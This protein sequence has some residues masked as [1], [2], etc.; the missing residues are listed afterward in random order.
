MIGDIISH[1]EGHIFK[2]IKKTPGGKVSETPFAFYPFA[3]Y[4]YN[5]VFNREKIKTF[6][7]RT[8]KSSDSRV[9]LYDIQ[10]V[11]L[12]KKI[13]TQRVGPPHIGKGFEIKS[14]VDIYIE[15]SDSIFKIIEDSML[16]PYQT[17]GKAIAGLEKEYESSAET[18]TNWFI[19][20][21]AVQLTAQHY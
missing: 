4:K 13:Q 21:L 7:K 15:Y 6:F 14:T 18:L 20:D 17:E 11:F 19:N 8:L 9:Q 2:R 10:L 1:Y 12:K 16:K 5:I 3:E